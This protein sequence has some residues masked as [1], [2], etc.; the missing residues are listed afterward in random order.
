LTPGSPISAPENGGSPE[1]LVSNRLLSRGR[2]SDTAWEDATSP[3]RE[4]VAFYEEQA[5]IAGD[6]SAQTPHLGLSLGDR[7]C[8]TPRIVLKVPVDTAERTWKK[9][10]M[11]VN[12]HVIR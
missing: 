11:G 2:V 3:V 1:I 8:L 10:K 6:L 9:L 4:I 7:T 5:R 12:V